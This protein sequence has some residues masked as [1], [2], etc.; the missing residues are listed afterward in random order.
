MKPKGRGRDQEARED[1]VAEKMPALQH[2]HEADGAAKGQSACDPSPAPAPR[3]KGCRGEKG[4]A[5]CGVARDE[6]AVAGTGP[7][8][9][10]G[11]GIGERPA[12]GLGVG[13]TGPA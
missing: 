8:E 12:E 3:Q 10:E 2:S 5:G 4:E 13:G 9:G 6:G 11:R 1:D 7:V